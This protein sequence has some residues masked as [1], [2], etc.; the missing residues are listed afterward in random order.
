[1]AA[2]N[3]HTYRDSY[4]ATLTHPY[5]TTLERFEDWPKSYKTPR[6]NK[7]RRQGIHDATEP[8]AVPPGTMPNPAYAQWYSQQYGAQVS[9]N[10]MFFRKQS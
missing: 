2:G 3:Y 4:P 8:F 10:D 6:S 9:L 5:A 1:M 7:Y